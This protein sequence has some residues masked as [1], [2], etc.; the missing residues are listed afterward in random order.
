M[1]GRVERRV[2]RGGVEPVE[3]T[4]SDPRVAL[5]AMVTV[6]TPLLRKY[7]GTYSE[8]VVEGV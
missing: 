6:Y 4:L 5:L 1:K 8:R 3:G 2:E 7:L